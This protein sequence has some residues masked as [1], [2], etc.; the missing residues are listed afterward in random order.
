LDIAA[1]TF[2]M[3]GE[4]GLGSWIL[5]I[6]R[7]GDDDCYK[8]LMTIRDKWAAAMKGCEKCFSMNWRSFIDD[9]MTEETEMNERKPRKLGDLMPKLSKRDDIS[10]QIDELN[11]NIRQLNVEWEK[12]REAA[13]KLRATIAK[14][15][16]LIADWEC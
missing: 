10:R 4:P 15:K 3:I 8:N 14:S 12:M 11:E 6:A 7:I 2:K 16:K 13:A 9:L 1:E 5:T